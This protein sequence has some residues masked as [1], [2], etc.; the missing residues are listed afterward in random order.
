MNKKSKNIADSKY[1]GPKKTFTKSLTKSQIIDL[2]DG[3]QET[4]FL[5]L[6]QGYLVRYF[7]PI[8]NTEKLE[9]Q[10]GGMIVYVDI[11][12]KYAIVTN[13]KVNWSV[14]SNCIFFQQ[15]PISEIKQII[16]DKY[17]D[18]ILKQND[19]LEIKNKVI[20][21]LNKKINKLEKSL[22]KTKS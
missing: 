15:M 9:F 16:E 3:Y 11:V 1:E 17:K 19:Q 14:Q 18:I 2:L 8:E 5:L 10:M 12:N 6:R 7:K 4:S 22:K 21:I 20:D 13:H